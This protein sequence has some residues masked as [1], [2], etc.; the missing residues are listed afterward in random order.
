MF[1]A[2]LILNCNNKIKFSIDKIE[3]DKIFLFFFISFQDTFPLV[4]PSS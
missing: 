2:G 3:F 1:E 4:L